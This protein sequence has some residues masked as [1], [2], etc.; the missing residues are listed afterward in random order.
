[1]ASGRGSFAAAAEEL[2]VCPAAISRMAKLLEVRLGV[3]LFER[4][5]NRLSLSAAGRGTGRGCWT[6]SRTSPRR[7]R[8]WDRVLISTGMPCRRRRGSGPISTMISQP[9]GEGS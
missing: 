9:G 8:R 3:A 5:A 1:M 2:H 6:G 7:W 4:R